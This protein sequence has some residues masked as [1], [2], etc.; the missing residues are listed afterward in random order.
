MPDSRPT[1]QP[2][3]HL[4]ER[5]ANA[6]ELYWCIDAE[7]RYTYLNSAWEKLFGYALEEMLG[8]KF[9]DFQPEEEAEARL[10]RL[11]RFAAEPQKV[12]SETVMRRK[13]GSLVRVLFHSE[14]LVLEGRFAGYSGMG[15]DLTEYRKREAELELAR[16]LFDLG[17]EGVFIHDAGKIVDCNRAIVEILGYAS[18]DEIIGK[19]G[20][21][22]IVAPESRALVLERVQGGSTHPIEVWCIRKDGSRVLIET[23]SKD[24][25]YLGRTM[26]MAAVRDISARRQV[27]T[28]LRASEERYRQLADSAFEAIFIH[29]RGLVVDVNDACLRMFGFGTRQEIIGKDAPTLLLAE[30]SRE[31][32]RQRIAM[33]INTPQEVT[34]VRP[35]GSKFT[36][37]TQSRV[38]EYGGKQMRLVTMSDITES[39]RHRDALAAEK[40]RLRVTLHSIG[41]GVIATDTTGR[42]QMMNTVAERL[43]GYPESEAAGKPLHEIFRIVHEFTRL[44]CEN[45][46]DKV[47]AT[48]EVIELANHT[49]LLARDGS[50]RVMA[51]SGAPIRD[52]E[53]RII[54]VVLVFRDITEK[55]KLIEAAQRSQKL[56]SLGIL[57]G[58][59]AHDFNNLLGGIYGYVDLAHSKAGDPQ[60]VMPLV[61]ALAT[62]DRARGLT[63]QLLTF[64]KGGA[65][66]RKAGALFPFVEDTVR[67]IVSGSAVGCRFTVEPGLPASKFDRNQIGQVIDNLA[68][69]AKQAM[70]MGGVIDVR[71]GRLALGKDQVEGLPPGDY[72]SIAFAD[73][74]IGIPHEILPRIFDPFFTTKQTGSGLGLATCYSILKQHDGGIAVTSEPGK[75]TTFI[76]YLPVSEEV[77]ATEIP[78]VVQTAEGRGLVLIMDDEE[79]IRDMI[80]DMLTD[81]GYAAKGF[82]EGGS[83]LEF[84]ERL[85]ENQAPVAII[86]D[87]TV[88]GGQGG[89]DVAPGIRR[90]FPKT[91]IIVSSG[92]A[93]DPIM[94]EPEKYGISASLGK[95]FRRSE[96]LS[97]LAKVTATR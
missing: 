46:V 93:D 85:P 47:L 30:E 92:Y 49:L 70:P 19:Q 72:V 56:E 74:G 8:R 94:A 9:S 54:G 90:K 41:D 43:T 20:P 59:I 61:R 83:I 97:V 27:E 55:Q 13:D 44:P 77:P 33:G 14:P 78:P 80:G 58:G 7:G 68:I 62:I 36:G 50:E 29:D 51:D 15:F 73:S 28:D 22:D 6:T 88:P 34:C 82:A 67:F 24:I 76:V 31:A 21:F 18:K 11:Q 52:A 69:N 84:L 95:P 25:R 87:L 26:R 37:L 5:I 4:A 10:A 42:V 75:G 32:L 40:E 35:D 17:F 64:A 71:A 48:G 66:I 79:V 86:L 63:Q 38:V 65:P 89:R 3:A 12:Q 91:A 53:G 39:R 45:P 1:L 81:Q 23:Q 60:I 96:L 2:P 16:E 57:A